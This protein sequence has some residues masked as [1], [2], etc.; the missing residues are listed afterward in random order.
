MLPTASPSK[1]YDIKVSAFE[2]PRMINGKVPA[3]I[4]GALPT[5]GAGSASGPT[6]PTML[7]QRSNTTMVFSSESPRL[8]TTPSTSKRALPVID[9]GAMSATYSP[10]LRTTASASSLGPQDA[11]PPPN[12]MDSIMATE[13]EKAFPVPVA[14]PSDSHRT[15]ILVPKSS[16]PELPSARPVVRTTASVPDVTQLPPARRTTVSAFAATTS[17]STQVVQNSTG[18]PATTP[19]PTPARR[20]LLRAPTNT[21]GEVATLEPSRQSIP[22]SPYVPDR[23]SFANLFCWDQKFTCGFMGSSRTVAPTIPNPLVPKIPTIPLP[24]SIPTVAAP[25]IP[26]PFVK[27]PAPVPL[28]LMRPKSMAVPPTSSITPNSS[29]LP[30]KPTLPSLSNTYTPRAQPTTPRE[31]NSMTQDTLA[32]SSSL[33]SDD[34]SSPRIGSPNTPQQVNPL[35][36]TLSGS[37]PSGS[38]LSNTLLTETYSIQILTLHTALEEE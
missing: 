24:G 31:P 3:A 2:L 22:P 33:M 32:G 38:L 20:P 4:P 1:P 13:Q 37:A 21:P 10:I 36:Q 30:A 9:N 29:L 18:A 23:S 11:T 26:L 5:Q 15:S 8:L 27:A 28:P 19:A 34:S 14:I 6:A 35:E 25:K 12:V 7:R 16:M 17:N